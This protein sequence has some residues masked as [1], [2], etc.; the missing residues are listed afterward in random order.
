[1]SRRKPRSGCDGGL[2]SWSPA[3]GIVPIGELL[4]N[5]TAVRC[6][7]PSCLADRGQACGFNSRRGRRKV[8]THD[9]RKDDAHAAELAAQQPRTET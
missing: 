6:R 9:C 7:W 2:F 8:D 3:D 1:M 5:P 4:V